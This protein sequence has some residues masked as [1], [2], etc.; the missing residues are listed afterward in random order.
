MARLRAIDR[1]ALVVAV[2]DLRRRG[3]DRL[4]LATALL[5]MRK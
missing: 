5:L 2:R 4:I 1:C 3:R